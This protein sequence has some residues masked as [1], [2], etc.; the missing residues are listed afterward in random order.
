MVFH[1]PLAFRLP[2]KFGVGISETIRITENGCE[3]LSSL[4]RDLHV[5]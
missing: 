4:P 3:P 1:T 2:G 5:A